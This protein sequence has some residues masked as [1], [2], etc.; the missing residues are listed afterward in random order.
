MGFVCKSDSES[1]QRRS[2]IADSPRW[3]LNVLRQYPN[4]TVQLY[5]RL[6]KKRVVTQ[7]NFVTVYVK[8][9]L[10]HPTVIIL[11]NLQKFL[12]G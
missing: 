1:L 8:I 10:M 6:Q 2:A 9:I 5:P 3:L 7:K 12:N 4:K 11:G